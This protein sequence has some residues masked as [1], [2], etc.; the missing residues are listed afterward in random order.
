MKGTLL[1]MALSC[2]MSVYAMQK[3]F[4]V[5]EFYGHIG[6]KNYR[7]VSQTLAKYPQAIDAC[8]EE[9]NTALHIAASE[10]SVEIVQL[11]VEKKSALLEARNNAEETPLFK[12]VMMG[13]EEIVR[14]LILAGANVKV[15]KTA[16]KS[17]KKYTLRELANAAGHKV[18]AAL[19]MQAEQGLIE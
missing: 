13:S 2:A 16:P 3:S 1:V 4:D 10:G 6:S 14:A 12:A 18:V 17:G 7:I 11:L 15:T 9:K 5:E 8:D 19:L